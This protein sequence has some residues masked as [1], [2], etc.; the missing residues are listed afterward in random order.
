MSVLEDHIESTVVVAAERAGWMARKVKWI[1]RRGAADRVFFG[2]GRCVW[3]EFKRPGKVPEGQ[4]ANEV[5]RMQ[6]AYAE[7]YVCDDIKKGLAILGIAK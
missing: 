4:Q 7:V 1:G 2:H 3:I 6:A 5:A